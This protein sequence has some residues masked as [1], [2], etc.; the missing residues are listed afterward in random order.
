MLYT[1]V[2]TVYSDSYKYTVCS[3]W[4]VTECY[5]KSEVPHVAEIMLS[6][7][8]E[9]VISRISLL[10]GFLQRIWMHLFTTTLFSST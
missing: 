7:F 5:S 10:S 2:N 6:K 9:N 4:T 1:E 8:Y 3:E